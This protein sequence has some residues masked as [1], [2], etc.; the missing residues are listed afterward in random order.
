MAGSLVG[1]PGPTAGRTKRIYAGTYDFIF[2]GTRVAIISRTKF[3]KYRDQW[4]VL[5]CGKGYAKGAFPT[6]REAKVACD[7]YFQNETSYPQNQ[8]PRTFRSGRVNN[9]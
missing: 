7:T 3:H 5:V 1:I 8:K 6:L 9:Q 2:G 4:R